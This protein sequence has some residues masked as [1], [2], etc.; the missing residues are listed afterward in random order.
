MGVVVDLPPDADVRRSDTAQRF[1]RMG[2][3][4]L[5][6]DPP[7]QCVRRGA[8]QS[9]AAGSAIPRLLSR[10]RDIAPPTCCGASDPRG[11]SPRT[12]LSGRSASNPAGEALPSMPSAAGIFRYGELLDPVE[13]VVALHERRVGGIDQRRFGAVEEGSAALLFERLFDPLKR[14]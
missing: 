9:A 8:E 6:G 11:T 14:H 7:Q 3:S 10:A 13:K 12:R 5:E 4:L 2:T 1:R